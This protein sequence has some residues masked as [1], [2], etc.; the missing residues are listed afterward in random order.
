MGLQPARFLVVP[1]LLALLVMLPLLTIFADVVSI[2]GGAWIAQTYAHI[3]FDSFIASARQTI[4]FE[5]V[6]KG[7]I[8]TLVFAAIIV[9]VG[10]YQGLTTRGGAAGVG[11]STTGAVV[12]SIILI[13][14]SNFILSFLLFGGN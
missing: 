1:R 3:S 4:G 10:A 13:F 9:L 5:D 6:V 12:L 8:K 11:K 14:I 2:I 7:L